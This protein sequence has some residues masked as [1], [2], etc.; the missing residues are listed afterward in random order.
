MKH[1]NKQTN[2]H[3]TKTKTK[4]DMKHRHKQKNQRQREITDSL[5]KGQKTGKRREK[6]I[7]HLI[8]KKTRKMFD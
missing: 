7:K 5:T 4:T 6:Q 1:G 3:E 8:Y 2:R